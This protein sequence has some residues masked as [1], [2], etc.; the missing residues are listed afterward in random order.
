M[1]DAPQDDES[2]DDV[3]IMAPSKKHTVKTTQP[4]MNKTVDMIG[5]KEQGN[6][7][8]SP[9]KSKK[10]SREN[11]DGAT[12]LEADISIASP[13]KRLRKTSDSDA[14]GEADSDIIQN[15]TQEPTAD[16]DGLFCRC[17]QPDDGS[18]MF[19]CDGEACPNNGWVHLDCVP[20]VKAPPADDGGASKWYCPD[21][22]PQAFQNPE[23]D[24]GGRKK[25][26]RKGGGRKSG[27]AANRKKL[28]R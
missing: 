3:P 26:K 16:S 9:F 6:K 20:E 8:A 4:D 7:L 13:P 23:E 19:A 27:G 11:E 5:N 18:H 22:D 15:T 21:C 2:E 12:N 28:V 25:G 24:G 14:E 17:K 10:R 1:T